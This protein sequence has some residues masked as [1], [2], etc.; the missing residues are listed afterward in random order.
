MKYTEL[1]VAQ[2]TLEKCLGSGEQSSV[3]TVKDNNEICIKL[4]EKPD[5]YNLERSALEK[6]INKRHCISIL[7]IWEN[8]TK[9]Q[10]KICMERGK[11]NPFTSTDSELSLDHLKNLFQDSEDLIKELNESEITHGDI[12]LGNIVLGADKCFKLIDFGKSSEPQNNNLNGIQIYYAFF[13]AVILYLAK[14]N[15]IN[16]D[17]VKL[18]NRWDY[19]K[20]LVESFD[21]ELFARLRA[22]NDIIGIKNLMENLL[23]TIENSSK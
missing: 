3:W 9:S 22:A 11:P 13:Q 6:V 16:L 1:E 7:G 2:M 21:N 23:K 20:H 8:A 10:Y 15:S 18:V 17:G 19:V 14:K 5:E 4:F 12:H